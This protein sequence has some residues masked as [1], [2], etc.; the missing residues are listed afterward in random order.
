MSK[1][2]SKKIKSLLA[3]SLCCAITFQNIMVIGNAEQAEINPE[4]EITSISIDS[5]VQDNPQES[6]NNE[7]EGVENSTP[8]EDSQEETSQE[9]GVAPEES[10]EEEVVEETNP[11]EVIENDPGRPGLGVSTARSGA[12]ANLEIVGLTNPN[13]I[14]SGTVT[15]SKTLNV[16]SGA[17]T[18]YD[19]IGTL[20]ANDKVEI[21]G[22]SNGW[23][24]IDFNG[25]EGYV[26]ASYIA[27]NALEKGIDVSK[28]NG[29]I[30]WKKV[31]ES[32]VSYA[33][34][35][36]G[37]GVSSVDERFHENIK[38]AI[39]AGIKVGVYWFSY[40]AST[41][42]VQQEAQKCLETIAPYKSSISY[43]V[44]FDYEYDSVDN[45]HDKNVTV[46]KDLATDM[47]NTFMNTV[48]SQGYVTGIYT[49][50][51]FSSK[52]YH[53]SI[54]FSN[55][56]WCAQ[57]NHKNTLGKPYSMWQ[58]TDKGTVPGISGNVDLNYTTLKT[59][60]IGSTPQ[61]EEPSVPETPSQPT[62]EKPSVPETPSQPTPEKPSVPETPSQPTPEKPSVPETPS[63]PTPEKPS[64]PEIPS[65]PEQPSVPETPSQPEQPSTPPATS[66]ETG[67]TTANVNFRTG[68]STSASRITTIPKGTKVE[69]IDKSISGWYKVN[70]N[71]KTGYLSSQYVS[72]NG[73]V[74]N[75]PATSSETGVTTANV[76][77]RTGAS[78]SA[79]RI[80]TIAKGTKVE[81]IDKSI[82]G[83]YKVNYNGKTGYL[84]SQYISLGG[85][86]APEQP[87]T[88]PATSS[89][90]GITT[91]N[92]NFRTG[93]STSAS[94]ITT[95]AKGT[96]VE[97][98]DK[99]ISGWYK[100]NYNGKTGYL[101]SQYV[102]IN[103]SVTNPPATSSETGVTT[104]NV[105][106]RTG[107]ST[108]A[109]R[110]TT[111]PK[112]TKVEV[113]DKSISGWYKVN[114]NGKTGYLSSQY[115]SINGSVTNPPATS[116]ETGVTTANVNLR[117]GAS[118]STSIITT[119]KK[120]SKVTIVDKSISGWYKV[121][122]SNKTGY[123]SSQYIK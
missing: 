88:P 94:R 41:E 60:N 15:A 96:K 27:L 59:F 32:G 36:A 19:K 114:Y 18:S 81:V 21:L 108:S 85:N 42:R 1:N 26:S 80:T 3:L 4:N 82:S 86:T 78:T 46:T 103:G 107:A 77:F 20:K 62:P 61:P 53:N 70:Y 43:P 67:V 10:T 47:A 7:E 64:V 92:V 84:S 65:Q 11:V 106:F 79:S 117:K 45:R 109:S 93:A 76:N 102:S 57:Y 22:T 51:D 48:K 91:A 13:A 69:V 24:K 104:A 118:T 49:N 112:G 44:F 72:I 2:I 122:Y 111:I 90:T 95:I 52:Y 71:G 25:K 74:T 40:A 120:G 63:Q 89:E 39:D 75:P 29:T 28:W 115:V 34:I 37:Y 123:V 99:S 30:D 9:T 100:V 66:S 14:G 23:Y 87:S 113:I 55:N 54:L 31:K 110:I 68:A 119:I 6:T 17:S 50:P 73:S 101:S 121:K 5:E 56:V 35:R 33:I 83:W 97:V 16:R 8:V 116:S 98:I 38:G 12:M 105:N 58:Y